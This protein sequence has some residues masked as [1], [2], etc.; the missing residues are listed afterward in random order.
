MSTDELWELR[1]Q[2]DR[3]LSAKVV[4]EKSKL[5]RLM[6]QLALEPPRQRRPY[7]KVYPRFRNPNP[8]YQTWSGRGRQPQWIRRLL[9]DGKALEEFRL[10]E[11]NELPQTEAPMLAPGIGSSNREKLNRGREHA[12]LR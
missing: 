5:E 11:R 9:E 6:A 7:S 4:S 10:S 2:V 3:T 1:E 12:K 8:P